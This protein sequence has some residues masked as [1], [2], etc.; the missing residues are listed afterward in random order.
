VGKIHLGLDE[1]SAF[2]DGELEPAEA[3]DAR[4]HL[5]AC[6]RCSAD[7]ASL[8]TLDRALAAAPIVPCAGS[9]DLRSALLDG[10]LTAAESEIARRHV[11]GCRACGAD[12]A[13]WLSTEASLRSLP[14]ALPSERV[15]AAMRR[16]VES[17]RTRPAFGGLGVLL[18]GS[19]LRVG[20]AAALVPAMGLRLGLAAALVLAIVVGL[21]PSAV[22]DIARPPA[23]EQAIVAAV[24]QFVLYSPTNTLY[25]LQPEQAAVD[26][27]DA[28]TNELRT[29][30][31]VGGKPTALAVNEAASRILVLDASAKSLIEIDPESNAVVGSTQVPLTGTPT[32]V[33][34]DPQGQIV[35]TAT[36]VEP[37]RADRGGPLPTPG[38]SSGEVAVLNGATK[39]LEV[40]RA[41][42]V[43]P[44]QVVT[45]P[46]GKGALF[47]STSATTLVDKTYQPQ[48]TLPGGV[49]AAFG[50]A[51]WIAVLGGAG[52]DA[53]LHL[54]GDGA[55]GPLRLTGI[56][57]AVT[58]MP[59]GGFAVLLGS[60]SGNGRIV[61]I[62]EAGAPVGITLVDQVGR[63]FAYDPGARRF[64]ILSGG[65]ILSASLPAGVVAQRPETSPIPT[66]PTTAL[67]SVPAS[68]APSA[69]ASPAPSPSS[70]PT[71]SASPVVALPAP[72]APIVPSTAQ[73]IGDGLYRIGLPDGRVAHVTAS[74]A[75]RLWFVDQKHMLNAVDLLDGRIF[76]VTQTPPDGE[77]SAI[78][79]SA[80]HLYM[81]DARSGRLSVLPLKD[82]RLTTVTLPFAAMTA[83][84][85]AP[86]GVAWIGAG[87]GSAVLI[88][89]EPTTGRTDV[90]PLGIRRVL[91]VAPDVGGRVW[92]SDGDRTIGYYDPLDK[93]LIQL[94][95]PGRGSASILLPDLTGTL[96]VGT[97][98]G[99][100]IAVQGRVARLVR[101]IGGPVSSL[102]LGP[103]GRPWY[104]GI[105]S[106]SHRATYGPVEAESA[107]SLPGPASA[108]AVNP[109]AR[110]WL[111]DASGSGLYLAL[112]SGR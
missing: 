55:P 106:V 34:V 39:K 64:A 112:E 74:T 13:A 46:E 7:L 32:S 71:T 68:A 51:G 22:P 53:V 18:P 31:S 102:A 62:D 88:R 11:A 2:A 29:R 98:A 105:E 70:S 65:K 15:E 95:H 110:A 4:S 92:F 72:S 26:A 82:E 90:V 20:S 38:V 19:G 40:T 111:V 109:R 78:A 56:P 37:G 76:P 104:L 42:E 85:V 14:A 9:L 61:V 91:A 44:Q 79:A 27:V 16:L 77:I 59:D 5:D 101:Q 60:G 80:S 43:A 1:L 49:G 96:W 23:P 17:G 36:V 100:V 12:Q 63:D 83:I 24:Q 25:V 41:L 28:A 52:T 33:R 58:S 97:T 57:L 67:P 86:D 103:S 94:P 84:G 35:V 87:E 66:A 6:D 54:I 10:Q 47:V 30:I 107:R 81:L 73:R 3:R 8:S 75:T 108:L 48:R 50:A 93:I 89:F 99:E 21:L 69:S 45:D